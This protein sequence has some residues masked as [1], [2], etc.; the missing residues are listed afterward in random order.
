MLL[1]SVVLHLAYPSGSSVEP[2]TGLKDRIEVYNIPST[3]TLK[4]SPLLY[5]H[6]RPFT[7]E[8]N[9]FFPHNHPAPVADHIEEIEEFARVCFHM[10][11]FCWETINLTFSLGTA[12]RGP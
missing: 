8:F 11:L 4:I 9:G 5:S 12:L 2:E 10:A 6:A 3:L 7:L 1:F